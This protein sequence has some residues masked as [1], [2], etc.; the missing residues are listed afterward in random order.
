MPETTINLVDA[1]RGQQAQGR[2]LLA[3]KVLIGDTPKTTLS[4]IQAEVTELQRLLAELEWAIQGHLQR[5][6]E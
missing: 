2:R 5:G 4:Q 6:H 1:L 3:Q